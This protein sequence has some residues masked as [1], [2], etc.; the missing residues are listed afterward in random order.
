MRFLKCDLELTA[1]NQRYWV[2]KIQFFKFQSR[3]SSNKRIIG[4]QMSRKDR[5]KLLVGLEIGTSKVTVLIG[6]AIS[7][8]VVNVI[9][10]GQCVSRGIVAGGVNNL[11]YVVK[12]I[13]KAIEKAEKQANYQIS[14]VYLALSG[15][16]INC[17]DI[18]GKMII[19]KEVTQKD[20]NDILYTAKST[21][22]NKEHRILH[23]IP[24]G[25]DID[26]QVGIKDP[27][28]LSG[29]YMQARIH[30]VSYH[31]NT[32]NNIIKAVERCSIRVKNLVFSGIASSQAVLTDIE[33]KLGVCL[34]DIGGGTMDVVIYTDNSI[35]YS[36]A[37]PYAGNTVTHDIAHAFSI[38]LKD[39]EKIKVR[40]G[41]LSD[42]SNNNRQKEKNIIVP[43]LIGCTSYKLC[44]NDLKKI[45][46]PRY[47]ELLRLV[48]KEI[49]ELKSYLYQKGIQKNLS[50]GVVFTGGASKILGF[51]SYAEAILNIHVRV[52]HNKNISDSDKWSNIPQCATTI[53]LLH[54]GKKYPDRKKEVKNYSKFISFI[55][56]AFSRNKEN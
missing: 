16:H 1:K 50:A 43:S 12:H 40:H 15:E 28:G 13:K 42:N 44:V 48:S 53:G 2:V 49:M 11:E 21:Y 9:G 39:A 26:Y 6:K 32:A 35:R 36:V 54:Y 19:D 20:I 22:S 46:K 56:Q 31:N 33:K 41:Y 45:I 27:V 25:Y 23:A 47:K 52:G 55:Q 5:K 4:H 14:S 30:L 24:Q 17:Q 51:T 10:V 37:I 18:I 7:N 38:S 3:K 34:V 29:K 8:D